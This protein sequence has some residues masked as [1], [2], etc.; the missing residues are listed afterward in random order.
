M[1]D[2]QFD[3]LIKKIDAIGNL[4]RQSKNIED[5]SKEIRV[6]GVLT[7]DAEHSATLNGRHVYKYNI[8]CTEK[9]NGSFYV[10][11]VKWTD[12]PKDMYSLLA[13]VSVDFKGSFSSRMYNGKE[14]FNFTIKDF[15]APQAQRKTYT[16]DEDEDVPF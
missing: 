3:T 10:N 7:K 12:S 6:C 1:T 13:G 4:L 2:E 9:H 16:E 8:K 15:G 5:E 11:A 14:Y